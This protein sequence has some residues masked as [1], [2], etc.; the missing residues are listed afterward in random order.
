M[1]S[2]LQTTMSYRD[3]MKDPYYA[4]ILYQIELALH[5]ADLAAAAAELSITDSQVNSVVNKALSFFAGKAPKL[6]EPA[7]DR[8]RIL[9]TA[10]S[11]ITALHKTLEIRDGETDEKYPVSMLK[12]DL[13]RALKTVRLSI[14][15]RKAPGSGSRAY[16]DFLQD[17]ISEAKVIDE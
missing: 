9:R 1:V 8:D 4:T 10:Y 2:P 11:A 12:R 16:L 7:S 6:A 3:L 17:F 5:D 13:H 15:D 14:K